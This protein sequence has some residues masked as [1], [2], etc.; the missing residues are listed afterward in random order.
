MSCTVLGVLEA[1]HI[2]PYRGPGD[3]H[4]ANG[5]LLRS[6]LHTL[7]DLDRIGIHPESL[8]ISIRQELHGTE[9]AAFDGHPLLV[10]QQTRPDREALLARWQSF[11]GRT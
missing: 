6:N 5:L 8:R 4:P 1:A 7:F 11:A 9:Y 3:N 10:S 2:R